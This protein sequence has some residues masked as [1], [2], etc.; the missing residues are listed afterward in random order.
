MNLLNHQVLEVMRHY[1][2]LLFYRLI[3]NTSYN[4]RFSECNAE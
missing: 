1:I 4:K 2:D 3:K